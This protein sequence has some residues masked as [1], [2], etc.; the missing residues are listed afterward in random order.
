MLLP[1]WRLEA[2]D[3][4]TCVGPR[5]A[6]RIRPKLTVSTL[7]LR[8]SASRRHSSNSGRQVLPRLS[9]HPGVV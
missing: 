2:I 3:L 8:M 6:G 7:A 1:G 5:P 4:E 9:G